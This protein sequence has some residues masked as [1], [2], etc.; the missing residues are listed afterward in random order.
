MYYN[1]EKLIHKTDYQAPAT[2]MLIQEVWGRAQES[3]FLTCAYGDE[4][5]G[6]IRTA[7]LVTWG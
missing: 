1:P 2:E 5:A 4:N 6:G 7:L 3:E